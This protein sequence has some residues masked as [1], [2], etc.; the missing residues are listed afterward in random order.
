[1]AVDGYGRGKIEGIVE[2]RRVAISTED[3]PVC[4]EV[5]ATDDVGGILEQLRSAFERIWRRTQ[6]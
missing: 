3:S 2:G 6:R 5:V 4:E 1:M